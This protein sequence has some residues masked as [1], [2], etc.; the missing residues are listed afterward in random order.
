MT[1]E[2][3]DYWEKTVKRWMFTGFFAWGAVVGA[4]GFIASVFGR[5]EPWAKWYARPLAFS[6]SALLIYGSFWLAKWQWNGKMD[7]FFDRCTKKLFSALGA[8]K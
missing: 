3:F 6:L 7:A 1:S 2:R 8:T 5:F 4:L